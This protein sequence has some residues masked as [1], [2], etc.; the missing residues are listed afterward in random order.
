MCKIKR[1]SY[2]QGFFSSSSSLFPSLASCLF[3]EKMKSICDESTLLCECHVIKMNSDHH[4]SGKSLSR[5]IAAY[6]V[7]LSFTYHLIYTIIRARK[8]CE[9]ASK[10][11][12]EKT[13]H[14]D[15]PTWIWP[16]I[17]TKE[18]RSHN[19]L[20]RTHILLITTRENT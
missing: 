3:K 2:F 12:K 19:F 6:W 11:K 10:R 7:S 18:F 17:W 5:K 20:Q 4:R 1:F 16:G 15:G 13:F 14:F 9:Q 8:F